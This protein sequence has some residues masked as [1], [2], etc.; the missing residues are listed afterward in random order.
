M[1]EK[2]D[3]LVRS[4][5]LAFVAKSFA[6]LKGKPMR[7]EPYMRYLAYVLDQFRKREVRRLL[8]TAPP[9]SFKT[10]MIICLA[11]WILAHEPSA[12][13]LIICYGQD[14]AER[15]S[16]AIRA[17]LNSKLFKRLF[18]TRIARDRSR[19]FDFVTT[20]GGGVLAL[21]IKGGVTGFGADYILIDD[22]MQIKDHDN[23][24]QLERVPRL[25]FSEIHT[26]LDDPDTG[27]LLVAMHRLHGRDLAAHIL[28]Q[29]KRWKH[30]NLPLIATRS[31]DFDLGGGN[32]WHR[33]KG[34]VLRKSFTPR[35]IANLK[36]TTAPPGFLALYQQNPPGNDRLRFTEQ[37]FPLFKT[38]PDG[39]VVFSIDPAQSGKAG[40]SYHVI[41]VWII[42]S[43][44]CYLIDQWRDRTSY[45]DLKRTT[46]VLARTYRPSLILIENSAQ[47]PALYSEIRRQ[48]GLKSLLVNAVGSKAERLQQVR[49]LIR[50]RFVHVKEDVPWRPDY[51]GEWTSYPFS[52]SD[53]QMDATIHLLQYIDN[54]PCPPKRPPTAVGANRFG[55]VFGNSRTLAVQTPDPVLGVNRLSMTLNGRTTRA[56]VYIPRRK[57]R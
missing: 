36:T 18:T 1:T 14:L 34:D 5:L 9:R 50:K 39:P 31:R 49:H 23:E 54:N 16:Y 27:C 53:D 21:S 6:L 55:P 37:H 33:A 29:G 12:K 2:M 46:R 48:E 57:W 17:I 56:L 52:A 45:V 7:I 51:I 15:T 30:V 22:P 41:Q 47:G 25:V 3:N 20:A 40:N 32:V 8:I 26:R 24:R 44:G 19:V 4:A 13:I 38:I 42:A 10:F 11:A 28:Q 43:D 35:V